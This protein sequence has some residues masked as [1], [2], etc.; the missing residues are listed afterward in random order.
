MHRADD[1]CLARPGPSNSFAKL[2][3]RTIPTRFILHGRDAFYSLGFDKSVADLGLEVV[4][5][6]VHSPPTNSLRERLIGTLRRE[7]LDWI[8]PLTEQHLRK[9][10]M[11]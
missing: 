10:L 7:C 5:T 11:L 1:P 3:L 2:Y 6:P 9:A 4:K 8:I